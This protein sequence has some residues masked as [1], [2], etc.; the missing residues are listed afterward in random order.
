MID[1]LQTV[2]TKAINCPSC[3]ADAPVVT[4]TFRAAP[5]GPALANTSEPASAT[6]PTTPCDPM[7]IPIEGRRWTPLLGGASVVQAAQRILRIKLTRL[8]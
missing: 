8:A 6:E 7:T 4:F 1:G 2:Q 5:G 3:P